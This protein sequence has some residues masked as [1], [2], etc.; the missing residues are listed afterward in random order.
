[1]LWLGDNTYYREVDW[2]SKNRDLL[3]KTPIPAVLPELQPLLSK[4]A[5]L[6]NLG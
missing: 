3:P 6:F 1:M 2:D 4:N 5:A